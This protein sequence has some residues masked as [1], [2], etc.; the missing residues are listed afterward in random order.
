MEDGGTEATTRVLLYFPFWSSCQQMD[1]LTPRKVLDH[2]R[3]AVTGQTWMKLNAHAR[4]VMTVAVRVS[5]VASCAYGCA[6]M[7]NL[8]EL[9]RE[10]ASSPVSFTCHGQ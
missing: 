3:V 7:C 6:E 2:S 1:W 8:E 9:D 4:R 5:T 10:R